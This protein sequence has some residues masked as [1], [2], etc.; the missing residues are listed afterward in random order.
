[1]GLAHF[2]YYDYRMAEA[3]T[4]NGQVFIKKSRDH[5]NDMFT[6]IVGQS[7]E[8][9]IYSDTD[10]IV[11]DSLISV[12]GKDIT[13]AELYESIGEVYAKQDY[14]IK[15]F[16]KPTSDMQYCTKSFNT[17]TEEIETRPIRYVMKH[18][19]KKRMYKI[20]IGEK[21]VTVTEDHSVI[22]KRG[23]EYIDVAPADIRSTD[24]LIKIRTLTPPE[25]VNG[26]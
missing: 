10:S 24:T 11:G 25:N 6:K 4:S 8:Y 14:S 15:S 21:S 3:V 20:T 13:I 1:M 16:V 12:N 22:V 9:G 18:R 19:V 17:K 23:N 2:R 7:S 26:N 5:L